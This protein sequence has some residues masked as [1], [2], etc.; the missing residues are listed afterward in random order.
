MR[1]DAELKMDVISEKFREYPRLR[2][3]G[4]ARAFESN[5]L[6]CSIEYNGQ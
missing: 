6:L 2:T 1:I 5:Q 3:P 4:F